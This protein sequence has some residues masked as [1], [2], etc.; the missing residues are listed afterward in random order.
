TDFLV[1]SDIKFFGGKAANYAFLRRQVP[2]NSPPAIAFSFDLWDEFMNQTLPGKTQTLRQEI[3]TMLAPFTNYPPNMTALKQTLAQIRTL[4]IQ[5]ASFSATQQQTITNALVLFDPHRK[6][7]FRSS[8]NVEDSET[9]TGAGLYDSYSGCLLDDL[10]SDTS[11]PSHCDPTES[12]ERGVFRAMQRVYASFYNDNAFLERLRHG[13]KESDVG[14]GVLVHY[15]FPDEDELAN[16][17][18]TLTWTFSPSWTQVGGDLVTQEGAESVTNPNGTSLPEVVKYEGFGSSGFFTLTRYSSL[19]PLGAHVMSW[20]K[21]YQGFAALFASIAQ[22][23]HAQYPQKSRFT[24]DFEYKKDRNLGLVVKQVRPLPENKGSGPTQAFLVDQ[25]SEL[26]VAQ[27]EFGDVFSNHRLKSIWNLHTRNM[28][29]VSS[30]LA[31]G[32]YPQGTI[33]Y[34]E[35]TNRLNLSGDPASWPNASHA[36]DGTTNSW[37]TGPE[38]NTRRWELVTAIQTNSLNQAP[39][40]T[41]ND[42]SRE[43]RVEYAK[44]VPTISLF[45][46]P[47]NTLQEI[48][49]LEPRRSLSGGSIRVERSFSTNGVQI[50]TV[51]HWPTPPRGVAAGYT[52]PLVQFEQTRITGLTSSPITLTNYYSQTYRPGHH[53]ITEEFIF[54]PRIEPGLSAAV[55]AE[56]KAANIQL[57]YV[58]FHYQDTVLLLGLDDKFRPL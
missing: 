31:Q 27:A 38:A 22:G 7:R 42:F 8:T 36:S 29:L 43:L 15:S 5:S 48:V 39:I 10:D 52:A 21:D 57:I 49:T 51:F 17:V 25:P 34:L 32:I 20:Q 30:N 13:V 18:A 23:F 33:E 28:W 6:I 53:N 16:G 56:L 3:A 4:I 55:R 46:G 9:F 1:P 35:N 37:T 44:P 47:T 26:V 50:T 24:L 41:Q 11:G 14:M 2:S 12:R 45:D 40:F 54:E 19:V 58:R